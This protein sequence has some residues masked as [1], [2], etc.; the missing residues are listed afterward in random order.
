MGLIEKYIKNQKLLQI[1]RITAQRMKDAEM[2][3]SAVVVAYY[4]LL[5]LFPLLLTVGSILPYLNLDPNTVLPYIK[6]LMPTEI[7]QQ[8]EPAVVNLLTESSTGVLSF[9]ALAT[10][11]SASKSINALQ[12]AMNKAYGVEG[13][14][15][16]IWAKIVSFLMM[17]LLIIALLALVLVLGIGQQVLNWFQ[18]VF[19]FSTNIL[20]TFATLKWPVVII[21]LV[22][23]MILIY[24]VLPN[25][26]IKLKHVLPGAIF[27]SI[28]W[29]LLSQVFGI[30]MAMFSPA[31]A[32]YQIIGSFI[33]LMLWL[34]FAATIIILGAVLN[35]VIAE[36]F[37]G[38]E[39]EERRDVVDHFRRVKD[40]F[41]RRKNS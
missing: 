27:T 37:L 29:L 32:S 14:R 28:G 30:Y 20:D 10:I 21:G 26:K 11:W 36:V 1:I 15:N 2:G 39:L 3:T 7:Y 25:A 5:F 8:L 31:M 35:A 34:N 41:K 33:V 17:F 23:V 6:E 4:L 13:R 24:R 19:H 16:F 9:S 12:N 40:W 18:S 38:E 22:V